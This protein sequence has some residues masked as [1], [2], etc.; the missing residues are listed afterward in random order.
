MTTSSDRLAASVRELAVELRDGLAAIRAD[1]RA[2]IERPPTRAALTRQDRAYLEKLLPVL[3]GC[4]G[5][6]PFSS[7]DVVESESAA[8]HLVAGGMGAKSI[9]RLLA[10][11]NGLAIDGL[12]VRRVGLEYGAAL[13]S[14]YAVSDS[15]ETLQERSPSGRLR[16]EVSPL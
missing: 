8:V 16:A 11:A 3:A 6:E 4:F 13:W 12:T 10:R 5:S 9:G 7:R 1:L 2:V 14:V 15:E